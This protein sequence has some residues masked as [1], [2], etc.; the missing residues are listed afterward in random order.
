[1]GFF[2]DDVQKFLAH[3][4]STHRVRTLKE[5]PKDLIDLC[6]NDYLCLSKDHRI[7]AALK[8]GVDLYGAGST[9][10][11]L[12]SGHRDVFSE[13]EAAYADWVGSEDGL[14]F[15]NG[16]A[17]NVGSLSAIMDGSYA[18]FADRLSHASLM[19]GIRLSGARKVYFHHN[20]LNHLEELLKKAPE[21]RRMIVT[22]SLF[23]MDGDFAPM[24]DLVQLAQKY[25]ALLY[26]DDAHALGLFG[27]A[28]S[29]LSAGADFRVGTF[30]KA[31]GLE[32]A[33]IGTSALAKKYL[34]HT[35]RTFVFST[36]PMPA[37]AHAALAAIGIVR[38]M[39]RER[40]EIQAVSAHLRSG[41]AGL[42]YSTG[43]SASHIIPLLCTSEAE[44]L[45]A[46][47]ALLGAGYHVKAIRP[48]TVKQS[49]LRISVNAGLS[50]DAAERFLQALSGSL[51]PIAGQK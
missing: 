37:I 24:A 3:L 22:E 6:S 31:L 15:A 51:G 2:T 14:F 43:N 26:V 44:A 33:V 41:I 39:D 29:G 49:R 35:A 27:N 40:V 7:T 4:E 46:A 5:P 18:A 32:G 36:A 50:A 45:S 1:M 42:G 11:R 28:G 13:L 17:A 47:N 30:G 21:Q 38:G 20:D 12:V 8:A 16:Y 25:S 48:P 23:S 10:S 9:A 19:D 34:L